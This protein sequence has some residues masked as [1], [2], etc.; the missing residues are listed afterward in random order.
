MHPLTTLMK[1]KALREAA[2]RAKSGDTAEFAA[3]ATPDA[4]IALLDEIQEIAKSRLAI[5]QDAGDLKT[6]ITRIGLDIDAAIRGQVR[7]SA[8]GPRLQK[9]ADLA[10]GR[11]LT[12]E[13]LTQ[14]QIEDVAASA[15]IFVHPGKRQI[16]V[17]LDALS[18]CD[19]TAKVV[20]MVRL[21][22][23]AHG[24]KPTS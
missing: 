15:G 23:A 19:S 18:G 13:P 16:R 7:E 12:R 6:R 2:E 20:S 22:E 9:I 5:G 3:M 8:V 21:I 17:G 4:V 24:V 11:P 14:E 1:H 10:A